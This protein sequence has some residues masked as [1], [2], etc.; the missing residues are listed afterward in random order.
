M[1]ERERERLA[2][3]K[4]IEGPKADGCGS[5]AEDG[6]LHAIRSTPIFSRRLRLALEHGEIVGQDA[7]ATSVFPQ[8]GFLGLREATFRANKELEQSLHAPIRD[9]DMI[10][11]NMNAP[12]STFI[13]GSQGAGKSH[14]LSCLLENAL[15]ESDAGV[16][17]NPLAGIMF[18]YDNFTS[19]ESTQVCEAAYLCSQGIPVRVLVSPINLPNMQKLYGNLPGLPAHVPRPRVEALHFRERHLNISNM[20]MLMAVNDEDRVPLYLAIVKSILREMA[21]ER[22]GAPG[23]NYEEFKKKI[24]KQA[25]TREQ[26]APLNMR[27]QLLEDFLEE[28]ADIDRIWS[29]EKGT[30][31]IVDLSCPFINQQDACALFTICLGLFMDGRSQAGRIIALDEAHK[32]VALCL[33]AV[34]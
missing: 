29:F 15:S 27:L 23:V 33:C 24:G 2:H 20:L 18:H 26:T 9:A 28:S 4:L 12:W 22:G 19:T 5:S 31:T 10:Y 17:P 11:A 30:L 14:T 21:L 32:V 8:Y 13:C 7:A 3:L 16:L 34:L 6:L 25:F 1:D